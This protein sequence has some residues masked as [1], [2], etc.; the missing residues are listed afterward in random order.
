V[1]ED[2]LGGDLCICQCEDG[3]ILDGELSACL[4]WKSGRFICTPNYSTCIFLSSEYL[5][6]I[7]DGDR[8]M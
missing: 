6:P 3:R 7:R 2:V 8:V 4:L 5:E 1:V